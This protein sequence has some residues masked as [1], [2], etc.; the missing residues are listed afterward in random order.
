[1][2]LV[3]ALDTAAGACSVSLSQHGAGT[4]AVLEQRVEPMARGH[5]EALPPMLDELRRS[6]GIDWAEIDLIAATVGPG[7]FTG[8]RIG[9]SAA[10]GLALATDR[11]TVAVGTLEALAGGCEAS[12]SDSAKAPATVL[13]V[14]DSRRGDAYTQAFGAPLDTGI[15]VPLAPAAILPLDAPA[16]SD[17]GDTG[18]TVVIGDVAARLVELWGKGS[19][20][21]GFSAV[22]VPFADIRAV[23][24]IGYARW[25]ATGPAVLTPVYLRP[26][27]AK[28]A[29]APSR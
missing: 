1:M 5:S 20:E 4:D 21:A 14:L 10:R 22:T 2:T 19:P 11:P 6:V 27:D 28:P 15:P 18:A 16:P 13:A 29:A 17:V 24:R 9:L 7:S 12:G 25:M 8:V 3:L 23:A 26:A